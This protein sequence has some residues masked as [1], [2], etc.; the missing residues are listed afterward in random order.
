MSSVNITNRKIKKALAAFSLNSDF[1]SAF[2]ESLAELT[3]ANMSG[4]DGSALKAATLIALTE[5][6]TDLTNLTDAVTNL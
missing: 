2:G 6:E 1:V 5:L 4:A 3:P